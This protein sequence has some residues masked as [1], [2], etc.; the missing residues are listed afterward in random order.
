MAYTP[1]TGAYDYG[2]ASNRESLWDQIKDLDALEN[3]VTSN[4]GS[5]SI[6]Q[7]V[8]SWPVDPIT[9]TSSQAGTI[10]FADTAF[11]ATNPTLLTN[12]T[13]IIEKGIAVA[14]S[15]QNSKHAG[16]SDKFAR[17]QL[18]K[19]KEWKQQL[20]FSCTVGS[21]VSGTGTAARTMQG[22][23]QFASTLVSTLA[24]GVSLT[25]DMLNAY[26]GNAWLLGGGNHDTV[27]VGRTLKERISSFTSGNT[28]NI[29]A[30]A[31]ELVGR[32][33]VYDS[34]HGRVEIVKHRYI[35]S[36][37]LAI[38]LPVLVTYI[39]DFVQ[40]GFLDE[41]HYEDRAKTGYYKAGSI[42]GEATLQVDN[43]KAV[44]RILQL[45]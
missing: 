11:A 8:H 5:V 44:Q 40:V 34:D 35:D 23:S 29:D 9:A 3:Y 14:M 42:V 22:L 25:S 38:S 39:K 16:F 17:E 6:G 31:A 20:E 37:P 21:L 2:D 32:V 12:T 10:E 18:K 41:P 33:D 19:M 45:K 27:L 28:R 36:A 43:E 7:K 30:K 26:L 24:S 1:S 13:Q 15:E 4:A